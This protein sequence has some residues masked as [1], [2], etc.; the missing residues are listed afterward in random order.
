MVIFP[1]VPLMGFRF[2]NLLGLLVCT[3]MGQTLMLEMKVQ[4]PNFFS[5]AINI[6]NYERPSQNV[7][8]DTI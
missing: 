2:H 5:R 6:I 1:V 7:I 8:A 3:V 4:Q